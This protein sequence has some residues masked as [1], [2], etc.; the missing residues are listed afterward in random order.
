MNEKKYENNERRTHKK[1]GY[2]ILNF[3]DTCT[4]VVSICAAGNT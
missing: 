1:L 2:I 3:Y 4:Y